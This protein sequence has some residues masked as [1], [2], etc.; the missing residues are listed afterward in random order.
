[1]TGQKEG[2]YAARPA[3]G[4]RLIGSVPDEE[5]E[6]KAQE[7]AGTTRDEHRLDRMALENNLDPIAGLLYPFF[8]TMT[9]VRPLF[10]QTFPCLCDRVHQWI[11]HSSTRLV[12]TNRQ[13]W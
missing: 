1:M 6:D 8:Q 5:S 4:T 2:H 3:P 9:N 7:Q 10:S 11:L 13:G 12:H